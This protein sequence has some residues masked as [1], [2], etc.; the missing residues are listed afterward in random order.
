M[1]PVISGFVIDKS[2]LIWQKT[3][4]AVGSC[5]LYDVTQLRHSILGVTMTS[6]ALA[7]VLAIIGLK[8]TPAEKIKKEVISI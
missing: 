5:L 7:L 3:G 6:Y 4:D 1:L 8:F 2:C